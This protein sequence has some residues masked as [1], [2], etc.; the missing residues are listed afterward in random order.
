MDLLAGK[1]RAHCSI[2]SIRTVNRKAVV[3]A[4]V[5]VRSSGRKTENKTKKEQKLDMHVVF[6]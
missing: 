4:V 6:S 3:L 2:C 5:W 1:R